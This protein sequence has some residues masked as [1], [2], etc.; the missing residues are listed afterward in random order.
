[1]NRWK[2]TA[3]RVLGEAA[4]CVAG[5]AVAAAQQAPAPPTAKS[6]PEKPWAYNASLSA[7]FLPRQPDYL[8]PVVM[9][10][11]GGL[12]LEGRYNYEALDSGSF[13]VGW[14]LHFGG[15]LSLALTPMVG[16]VVGSL[17]GFAPGCEATLAYGKLSLFSSGE[18]VI[19]AA[20]KDGNFFYTWT[21]LTYAPW[22]WLQ[23]GIVAQR[24]RAYQS[25]LDIQ[26]G[27]LVGVTYKDLNLTVNV[28]NPDERPTVVLALSVSF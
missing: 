13:W 5:A 7:Y 6:A 10:D 1:M 3:R 12:H 18:Y 16:G 24:T 23:V 28:F 21:Q 22:A 11:H 26:R 17:D 8:D 19:D 9:A 15:D 27:F 2:T 4:L 25:D 14:N 20:G